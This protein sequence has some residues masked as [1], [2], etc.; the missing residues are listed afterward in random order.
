MPA[1]DYAL[2]EIACRAPGGTLCL[3][4]A[5]AHHSLA[6]SPGGLH[7]ALPRAA[8]CPVT[9]ASVAWHHFDRATFELGREQVTFGSGTQIAVYS[10]ERS[11]VDAFRLR[12]VCGRDLPRVAL[13][14][15]CNRPESKPDD[16]MRLAE[17]FPRTVTPI[18][19]ALELLL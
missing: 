6:E 4:T 12:A 10:A 15:W 5:L 3:A 8:R 16:L 13:K 17:K 1:E 18:S 2:Q 9:A 7:V 14:R 19:N 11:I